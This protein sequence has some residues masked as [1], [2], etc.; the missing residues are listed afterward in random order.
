MLY[1][2]RIYHMHPGRMQAIHDR[3]ANFTLGIF[4]KHGIRVT[5]F[6]ED[7]EADN[8]RLCYVLEYEDMEARNR[9][10][11]EFIEDPEWKK[12]KSESEADGPIVQKIESIYLKRA[13]YFQRA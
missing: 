5:D 4:E 6:W 10:F 3:F 11:T 8:N 9:I 12:V 13:P 2:L 7:M 1:E